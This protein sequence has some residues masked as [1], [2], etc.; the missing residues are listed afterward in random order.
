[1]FLIVSQYLAST[2]GT[3]RRELSQILY[4]HQCIY[5]STEDVF[6]QKPTCQ[7]SFKF[8]IEFRRGRRKQSGILILEQIS[9][10]TFL[11]QQCHQT[12][13]YP[14]QSL[15]SCDLASAR[16]LTTFISTR[17]LSQ[18]FRQ[19]PHLVLGRPGGP[20]PHFSYSVSKSG[21]FMIQSL[22]EN[23]LLNNAHQKDHRGTTVRKGEDPVSVP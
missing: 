3:L 14:K 1:M 20:C 17:L 22:V 4:L 6:S 19:P 23:I 16:Q 12:T 13:C 10:I 5:V 2:P 11:I 15:E 7:T 21:D 9:Y 18:S 8:T